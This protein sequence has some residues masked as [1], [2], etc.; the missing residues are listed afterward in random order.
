MGT[1]WLDFIDEAYRILHWKGELWIAEIKSRF[2]RVS[3]RPGNNPVAHS[4]GNRK[5]TAAVGAK[6][7]P[8][9]DF[10]QD[11]A[12]EVDGT[13]DTRNET[14][15]SAFVEAL[16]KRGFLLRGEKHEA[17]DMSNRMFVKM[18]FIKAASPSTGDEPGKDGASRNGNSNS[19]AG[20]PRGGGFRKGASSWPP[21]VEKVD[22][23]KILKPCVYKLR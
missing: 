10:S 13:D 4:V 7:K 18:H 21:V 17:I 23:S 2:G 19:N 12:V 16:R 8:A 9:A 15:V 20:G 22:E 11:L 6:G 1:N 5:K 3:N 14:D